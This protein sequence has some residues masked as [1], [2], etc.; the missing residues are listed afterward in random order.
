MKKSIFEN[1]REKIKYIR[2]R[3]QVKIILLYSNII[4]NSTLKNNVL[5]T[6]KNSINLILNDLVNYSTYRIPTTGVNAS[7]IYT[8]NAFVTDVKQLFTYFN[9]TL[10][11]LQFI[12][13]ILL[14]DTTLSGTQLS[15]NLNIPNYTSLDQQ[16][17]STK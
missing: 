12:R 14:N 8:C 1:S 11:N 6:E 16:N 5:T 7:L 3:I 13:Y 17:I 4:T 10:D 9:D 15:I 2:I